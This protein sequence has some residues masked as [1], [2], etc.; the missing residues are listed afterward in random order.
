MSESE[1]PR[2]LK[3]PE[4]LQIDDLTYYIYGHFRELLSDEERG[5]ERVRT[6]RFK[7]L[8]WPDEDCSE[9]DRRKRELRSM[10]FYKVPEVAER[11]PELMRRIEERGVGAVM[12]EAAQRVVRENPDKNVLH[13]CAKCGGLCRTPKA[14]QCFRCGHDWH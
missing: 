13:L 10:K 11:F 9:D 1:K 4:D 3:A 14:R 7:S 6:A 2:T 12:N 5:A 8:P